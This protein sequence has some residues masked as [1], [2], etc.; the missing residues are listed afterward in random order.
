MRLRALTF[1]KRRAG[2]QCEEADAKSFSVREISCANFPVSSARQTARPGK[3][4]SNC[5]RDA[6]LFDG[7]RGCN[8]LLM[9]EGRG[10]FIQL[11]HPHAERPP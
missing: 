2:P 9:F 7:K 10:K 6:I 3:L 5:L 8:A 11:P 1:A 4:P